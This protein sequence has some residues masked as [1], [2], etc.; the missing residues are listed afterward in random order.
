MT[1][2]FDLIVEEGD[3]S[4]DELENDI[5]M[6]DFSVSKELVTHIATLLNVHKDT[7]QEIVEVEPKIYVISLETDED[8]F[9]NF[10]YSEIDDSIYEIPDT[11]KTKKQ[12]L[13]EEEKEKYYLENRR[14]INFALKKINRPDGVDFRELEDVGTFGFVKALNTFDTSNGTRFS[15]YAVKCVLNEVYYYLR[16]EQKHLAMEDSM[17]KVLTSDNQ[18]NAL[19]LEDTISTTMVDK[20]KT[21]EQKILHEELRKTLLDCLS[22]LPDDEQYLIIY[23]YGLDNN[24]ILTQTEIADTLNMSQANISKL[25]KTCLKKLRTILKRN[26][27][28]YDA[29]DKFLAISNEPLVN[30]LKVD[31][32]EIFL[33]KDARENIEVA[34]CSLL[35]LDITDVKDVTPTKESN[36][37]LVTFN[38]QDRIAILF[39]NITNRYEYIQLPIS[40]RDR[41]LY[42]C[43]GIPMKTQFDKDDLMNS[44]YTLN[45]SDKE[46]NKLMKSLDKDKLYILTY[47]YGLFNKKIKT[48][49]QIAEDLKMESNKVYSLEREAMRDLRTTINNKNKKKKKVTKKIEE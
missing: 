40:R 7:I 9:K 35:N 4:L 31:D 13:T 12:Y 46:F 49:H 11:I 5:Q 25:E 37:Y 34:V 19:T 38:M 22:Y 20:D 24:I 23:R 48:I 26:N 33:D 44:E 43:Y 30:L 39:N 10:S 18:G 47:K 14:L 45:I 42:L 6:E 8:T 2:L 17:D 32:N 29:K 15:T 16:K 28:V 21:T 36:I 3:T 27:Y 1:D 41:F